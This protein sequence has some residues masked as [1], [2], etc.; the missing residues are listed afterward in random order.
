MSFLSRLFGAEPDQKEAL[1]ALWHRTVGIAREDQWYTQCSVPDTIEGRYDMLTSI[2]SVVLLR[3]EQTP[4]L[5]KPSVHLTEIFIDDM[6]SQLR[7]QGI[8]DPALGKHMGKIVSAMG[9]RLGAYR[10]AFCA[11]PAELEAAITRNVGLSG[12]ASCAP[13][14]QRIDALSRQLSAISDE[15]VLNGEITR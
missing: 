13:L 12:D 9:G 8:G 15:A 3:M 1:R 14:A 5:A 11:G 10:E 4:A 6:D 7:E 2:L